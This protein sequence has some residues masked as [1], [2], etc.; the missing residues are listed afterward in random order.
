MKF[1]SLLA[2]MLLFP[3][4]ALAQINLSTQTK[5]NLP[6]ARVT[7]AVALDGTGHVARS[8]LPSVVTTYQGAW[9]SGTTYAYG[10][11]VSSAGLI[12]ISNVAGNTAVLT[13]TTNWTVVSASGTGSALPLAGGTMTGAITLAADPVANLQ[14]S[15]KQY[16]DNKVSTYQ[17]AL[18]FTAENIVHRGATSGYAPLDTSA[19][20]PQAYLYT[21]S[22]TVDGMLSHTDWNTFNAKQAALGYTAED[23]SHKGVASGYAPLNTSNLLSPSFMTPCGASGGGHSGGSVPDPGATAGTGRYL[24]EDCTWAISGGATAAGGTYQIQIKALT[25]GGLAATNW[26]TDATF[27]DLL[28]VRDYTGQTETLYAKDAVKYDSGGNLT[29]GIFEQHKPWN[30]VQYEWL[31]HACCDGYQAHSI[32]MYVQ[33]GLVNTTWNNGNIALLGMNLTVQTSGQIGGVLNMTA[34]HHGIG[35][36]VGTTLVVQGRG[37][38]RPYDESG[39][40]KRWMIG[41]DNSVFGGDAT[42][43]TVTAQGTQPFQLANPNA[44]GYSFAAAAEEMPFVDITSKTTPANIRNVANWPTDSRFIE[45]TADATLGLGTSSFTT[46]TADI[47]SHIFTGTCP[48]L[49]DTGTVPPGGDTFVTDRNGVNVWGLTHTNSPA[50]YCIPV[51][52][53]AGM[54]SGTAFYLTDS[55]FAPEYAKVT[56]VVDGTHVIAALKHQHLAGAVLSWGGGVGYGLSS[57]HDD[58]AIGTSTNA[59]SPQNSITRLVYP[60]MLTEAG[61]KVVVDVLGQF[62]L[63]NDFKSLAYANNAP[64]TPL[65]MTI[66]ATGNVTASNSASADYGTANLAGGGTGHVAGPLESLPAPVLSFTCTT[67]P[68]IK[69]IAG[70]NSSNG[71][72]SYVPTTVTPGTGCTG[73]TVATTAPNPLN[74]YPMTWT[75]RVTDPASSDEKTWSTTGYVLTDPLAA[76]SAWHT[77][78]QVANTRWWQSYA[79]GGQETYEQD[80]DIARSSNFGVQNILQYGGAQSGAAIYQYLNLEP[81]AHYLGKFTNPY[82]YGP[83]TDPTD[84]SKSIGT[85]FQLSNTNGGLALFDLPPL[86]SIFTVHCGAVAND[87]LKDHP[88]AHGTHAA[89]GILAD[90]QNGPDD[91]IIMD[92]GNHQTIFGNTVVAAGVVTPVVS[93]ASLSIYSASTSAILHVQ[94]RYAQDILALQ[95]CTPFGFSTGIACAGD[96][97]SAGGDRQTANPQL[98]LWLGYL[99]STQGINAPNVDIGWS[100]PTKEVTFTHTGTGTGTS[101]YYGLS[102][103]GPLGIPG[104]VT[105]GVPVIA[106]TGFTLSSTEKVTILCP[107]A[108]QPGWPTGTY[109]LYTWNDSVPNSNRDLGPCALGATVVDDGT[110]T[111]LPGGYGGP[112]TNA[113][114]E[115]RAGWV[116]IQKGGAIRFRAGLYDTVTDLGMTRSA[117]GVLSVDGATAADGLGTIRMAYAQLNSSTSVACTSSV[118]GMMNYVASTAGVADIIRICAKDASNTWGWQLMTGGTSSTTIDGVSGAFTFTGAGVSHTGTAY[119]F[120]GGGGSSAGAS[121]AVQMAGTAGAFLDSTCSVSSG[122]MS[123]PNGFNTTATYPQSAS[124]A[125]GTGSIPTLAANSGGWAG[126][127]TGGTPWLGKLP[128]TIG[129]G[130]LHFAAPA[131]NDGVNESAISSSLVSLTNDVT[132]NLA[133]GSLATQTANTLLGALSAT[134][135][136][137]IAVPSCSGATNALTWTTGTGFGCN[138]ITGSGGTAW[139]ALTAPS[140]ALAITMPAGDTTSFTWAAQSAPS[141]ADWTMIA[142][143][144][145]GVSTANA[146]DILDTTGNTKTG[147]L[148]NIHTVGTSTA[149]PFR[150]TAQGTANGVEVNAAGTFFAIGTG[151]I[152][153]NTVNGNT[154]PASNTFTSGG[155]FCATSTSTNT[156]SSLLTANGVVIGGGAGVCPTSIAASTTVAQALFATAGAPAFRNIL[157]TDIPTLN[158]TTSGSAAKWTTPVNLAG[159]AVDGSTAVP[160][161]NKFILQ[162]TADTG[163]TGA[164][165][166]GALATGP[167][168]NTTTT[169]ILSICGAVNLAG[170]VTGLLPG[171]NGGTGVNNGSNTLTYGGNILFS[172]AFNP[173]FVIPSSSTWTFPSGSDTIMTLAATQ[174]ASNKTFVAPALGN[175]LATSLLASGIV[176]GT[177][178]VTVTTGTT[179]TLGGTYKSGYT[180][181]QEATAATAVAYTLPT[182]AAGLQYCIDNSWNGTAATTGVLTLNTSASGQFII[183]T[184]GTLTATGGNVTSGGA[185]ADS[186]CVRGVDATHWQLYVQRGTWTKH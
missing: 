133:N 90:D 25:G 1:K 159:N 153:A 130:L 62:A 42:L 64:I 141:A 169:G 104:A 76:P 40:L 161:T 28:G 50:N 186:A 126:P 70:A 145:T 23:A 124:Y 14:P 2:G 36:F 22:T 87:R 27:N 67:N 59:V 175:A 16:V 122:A 156:T 68:V 91:H 54:S 142:G 105:L 128:A 135:P 39:E 85:L 15:T 155:V 114:S 182:A 178:P 35:D 97:N 51:V 66:D 96:P 88:C 107:S 6:V 20:L 49:V 65:T 123:C 84:S 73:V 150:V 152:K 34:T 72:L 93:T 120:S 176:D 119:T 57:A 79:H 53:T 160:F 80:N 56:T 100:P 10:D 143:A 99:R 168:C 132:G 117:A 116:A 171:A 125:A 148:F 127:N 24:R 43:G 181:N 101:R 31:R 11:M 8:L 167:L 162:G 45:I 173:T 33:G 47:T 71:H 172:G 46:T 86:G 151:S 61:N 74:L 55:T 138:T 140:A 111:A 113:N 158:Q 94:N 136:S 83:S 146:I 89:Y 7:G 174:T 180:D 58:R 157:A 121:G 115:L 92:T 108:Y 137:G 144:D 131:T 154:Y 75:Y 63:A 48:T 184:D 81:V 41:I 149:L 110:V 69:L 106:N 118:P 109:E 166:L 60:I 37:K 29:G 78:D 9:G 12:Y 164:Q 13:N 44:Y 82:G 179:A 32:D 170:G 177:A 3:L 38:S 185:A 103:I 17:P 95:P 4:A 26:K 129:V 147:A 163:L 19:K 112:I 5:G 98:S 102:F 21:A 183:F 139:S 52:S 165:F 134:T 30:F 18:G 77:G